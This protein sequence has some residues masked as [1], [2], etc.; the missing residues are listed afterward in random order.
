MPSIS[1][2][3]GSGDDKASGFEEGNSNKIKVTTIVSQESTN[4]HEDASSVRQLL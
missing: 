2:G 4:A 3:A 1:H